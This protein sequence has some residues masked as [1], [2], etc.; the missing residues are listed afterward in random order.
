M[1]QS[2]KEDFKYWAFI[3]YSHEDAHWGK[4]LHRTIET[5]RI[6]KKLIG[7]DSRDSNIPKRLFPVFRDREEL[8]TSSDLGATINNALTQSRY[9]VV[10]CSPNSANS[11]WVGEEIKL[12]KQMGK[13]DRILC[14]IV[15]GEPNASDKSDCNEQECFHKALRY[16]V[17]SDG[18]YTEERVEAIAADSR[19]GKDSKKASRLKLIAGLLDVNFDELFQRDKQRRRVRWA[20]AAAIVTVVLGIFASIS[21]QSY[22]ERRVATVMAQTLSLAKQSVEQTEAGKT[23]LGMLMALAAL[24]SDLENPDHVYA[25]E[26]ETALYTAMYNYRRST[27]L[28]QDKESRVGL[29][30]ILPESRRIVTST[31]TGDFL[32]SDAATNEVFSVT[33]W[34]VA[35]GTK[36]KQFKNI[37]RVYEDAISSDG[38]T[39]AIISK[40]SGETLIVDTDNGEV[41]QTLPAPAAE[42]TTGKYTGGIFLNHDGSRL[43]SHVHGSQSKLWDTEKGVELALLEDETARVSFSPDGNKLLVTRHVG[44]GMHIW[45]AVSGQKIKIL[46]EDVKYGISSPVSWF[47]DSKHILSVSEIWNVSTGKKKVEIEQELIVH[48]D[49]YSFTVRYKYKVSADGS[50]IYA[51]KDNKL[52]IWNTATGKQYSKVTIPP[53]V[54]CPTSLEGKLMLCQKDGVTTLLDISQMLAFHPGMNTELAN[55]AGRRF[56]FANGRIWI[57]EDYKQDPKTLDTFRGGSVLNLTEDG[58]RFIEKKKEGLYLVDVKA[59]S[60]P[61]QTLPLKGR[62]ESLSSHASSFSP[63]GQYL[64]IP[65]NFAI[66]ENEKVV[67][68]DT[69]TWQPIFTIDILTGH[70][71]SV[72]FSPDGTRLAIALGETWSI[73][74]ERNKDYKTVQIWDLETKTKTLT[75][76]GHEDAVTEVDYSPDGK[77]I[78]TGSFDGTSRIWD[79]ETGQEKFILKGHSSPQFRALFSPDGT[80]VAT[81]TATSDLEVDKGSVQLWNANTGELKHS[82][83]IDYSVLYQIEMKFL[84]IA[85]SPDGKHLAGGSGDGVVYVWDVATGS[86]IHRLAGQHR[87][88]SDINYSPNGHFI[89]SSTA[90]GKITIWDVEKGN[91]ISTFEV[92][93]TKYTS[94]RFSPDSKLLLIGT[95]NA[96]TALIEVASGR[97]VSNLSTHDG[98][99]LINFSPDGKSFLVFGN[100]TTVWKAFPHGQE[101]IEL[102]RKTVTRELTKEERE[103]YEIH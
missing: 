10:I 49:G 23:E 87:Y 14:L 83:D 22:E 25:P 90:E 66:E 33:L 20:Q 94:V 51:W 2:N 99:T 84:D 59:H 56:L 43:V 41:K 11:R 98:S 24:P 34:D 12:F 82:F 32:S 31:Y 69:K 5:Y 50:F 67:V 28:S 9:L 48:D 40:A 65:V 79:A 29:A 72:T 89:A 6:P 21:Y 39:L 35:T 46:N 37:E 55:Y 92:A 76:E 47:P 62:S 53:D 58:S 44:K 15:D 86:E 71:S 45:D 16:Q 30:V 91:T 74:G 27:F 77:T 7:K 68:W 36:I 97:L 3:S 100:G 93:E 64:A 81:S 88:I 4:W 52:V 60:T 73:W 78:L 80:W 19:A 8:P 63:N 38:K 42:N 13:A 96:D 54:N 102:A 1:E 70:V 103:L 85:F 95:V 17:A 18:S 57:S 75:L 26:A 61:I 101:L